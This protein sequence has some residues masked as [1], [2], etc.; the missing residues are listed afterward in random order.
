L[1]IIKRSPVPDVIVYG[2]THKIDVQQGKPLV[3][4]PGE[5]GGWLTGRSTVAILDLKETS[6]EIRDI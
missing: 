6:V 5:A 1:E 2:H 4:N 3:I